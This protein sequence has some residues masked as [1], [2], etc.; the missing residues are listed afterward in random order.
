M[1]CRSNSRCDARPCRW[2]RSSYGRRTGLRKSRVRQWRRSSHCLNDSNCVEVARESGSRL[3]VRDAGQ[4]AAG[5]SLP[6]SCD[7]LRSLCRRLR[8]PSG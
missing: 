5:P 8:E 4:G 7:D 1:S 6:L 2:G 3:A